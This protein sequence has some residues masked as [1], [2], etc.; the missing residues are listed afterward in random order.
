MNLL[1]ILKKHLASALPLL[2]SVLIVLLLIRSAEFILLA[3]NQFLEKPFQLFITGVFQD[4]IFTLI[5]W[6]LCILIQIIG[7][8]P[9]RVTFVTLIGILLI[10]DLISGFYFN[11]SLYPIDRTVYAFSLEE[12]LDIIETFGEVKWY[13]VLILF[14]LPLLYF[15]SRFFKKHKKFS[16]FFLY[17]TPAIILLFVFNP[18]RHDTAFERL[19][20]KNGVLYFLTDSFEYF[21]KEKNTAEVSV[22]GSGTDDYAL[23]HPIDTRNPLGPYF[24]LKEEPPNLVFI[25]VESL[26]ASFSGP[27]ADELSFTPYLDS[28]AAHSLYFPNLI[29]T[30][31]R[32]F[33]V[34]P[35]SLASLPHGEKGFFKMGLNMPGHQSILNLLVKNGYTAS[36]FYG[37]DADYD[38]MR[39][40][41]ENNNV[42]NIFDNHEAYSAAEA[43]WNEEGGEYGKS[44]QLFFRDAAN[45]WQNNLKDPFLHCYL[46]LSMH[47]PFKV[48]NQSHYKK[49]ARDIIDRAA[50]QNGINPE[51]YTK[52][53]QILSTVVYT[54]EGIKKLIKRYKKE[55]SFD[56][57][58]FFIYGDHMVGPYPKAN[59]LKKYE[60][61]LYIYSP[62]LRK[63][64]TIR[65][66]NSHLDITPSVTSLL[67]Y[68]Y[69]LD[70]PQEVHWIG[71][72]FD[73]NE[74]VDFNREV[75]LML[76]NRE[77]PDFLAGKFYLSGG[78]LY[79]LDANLSPHPV[80]SQTALDSIEHLQDSLIY[81]QTYAIESNQ[82][83]RKK[84]N[85]D[86]LKQRNFKNITFTRDQEFINLFTYELNQ[87]EEEI[88]ANFR[89]DFK[90]V[91]D[92]PKNPEK[93]P[94]IVLTIKGQDDKNLLWTTLNPTDLTNKTGQYQI[95]VNRFF[96]SNSKLPL[97]AGTLLKIY[98][99]NNI[100]YDA[101]FE[102][103]NSDIQLSSVS[104]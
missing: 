90:Q 66:I 25:I 44:D 17:A 8:R 55:D 43:N 34:I 13:Y 38:N 32:T 103:V 45:S 3:Q 50:G 27:E 104:K 58:I 79:R 57:T 87:D 64:N 37:G 49:L 68:R 42:T 85:P 100:K 20:V 69:P 52:Y 39:V 11:L 26:S 86:L 76:N 72:P 47:L 61:P 65:A 70:F 9:L 98:I 60:V 77:T 67:R 4:L 19:A 99:W 82:L 2:S 84:K 29:S 36:F 74:E 81:T 21:L 92:S 59:S 89:I 75:V 16:R 78:K 31:E 80:S 91:S 83:I 73:M 41:M 7:N 62:L 1:R 102:L 46:T 56:N 94:L 54:D 24:Q 40:F 10:F 14:P 35:S 33:G 15:L 30:A 6:P 93:L 95:D 101:T 12:L 96:K 53:L 63:P 5:L 51:K 88:V 18:N 28:L 22:A 48:E 23:I 97:K 71:H